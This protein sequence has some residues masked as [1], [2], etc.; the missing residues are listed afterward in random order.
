MTPQEQAL[1]EVLVETMTREELE[2]FTTTLIAGYN[3]LEEERDYLK[4]E[5]A[6][7]TELIKSGVKVTVTE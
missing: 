2:K 3:E 5:V 4:M 6:L 1:N 7:L